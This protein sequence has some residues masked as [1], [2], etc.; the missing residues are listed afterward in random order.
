MFWKVEIS[1]EFFGFLIFQKIHKDF[2]TTPDR[3][4]M[5]HYGFL[6]DRSRSA[7]RWILMIF[8]VLKSWTFVF[9]DFP[10]SNPREYWD[11]PRPNPDVPLWI[12]VGRYTVKFDNVW[13]FEKMKVRILKYPRGS[14]KIQSDPRCWES[15]QKNVNFQL[16][17]TL[18]NI[19]IHWIAMENSVID[20]GWLYTR[21]RSGIVSKFTWI[22]WKMRRPN[23]S[24]FQLFRT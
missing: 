2:E 3:F 17:K 7:I 15:K 20:W 8:C 11:N 24:N 18:K 14:W 16:S 6:T 1:I 22:F 9:F 5:F 13:C 10:G 19:K 4:L 21:N 23:N 12:F